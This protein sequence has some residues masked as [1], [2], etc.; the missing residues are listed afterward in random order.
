MNGYTYVSGADVSLFTV[1]L[2][3]GEGRCPVLLIRDPYVDETETMTEAAA[4][5]LYAARYAAF[6]QAG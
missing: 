5:A 1:T 3:P 2:L 4:V 6:V